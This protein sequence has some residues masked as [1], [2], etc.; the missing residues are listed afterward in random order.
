MFEEESELKSVNN[1]DEFDVN[2]SDSEKDIEDVEPEEVTP[3]DAEPEEVTTEEAAPEEA[4]PEEA[5][6]EEDAAESIDIIPDSIEEPKEN[7]SF[8]LENTNDSENNSIIPSLIFIV[9]YR[10]RE[11][12]YDFF[13]KHMLTILE[14]YPINYYKILYIH[15]KDNRSFN[16]G[17]M[18]NIGFIVVKQLYP[19]DYQNITLVFN[20]I[21]TMPYTK[22]M[23]TFPTKPGIIKHF[24]GFTYCLGGIVS[25]N[26][27]DFEM[28]NGFPNFWA[29]G[30]ED[31]LLNNRAKYSN[32]EID[33]SE[34]YNILDKNILHFTEGITR[35]VNRTE[36]DEYNNNTSEG[37]N[38]IFNL[39]YSINENGFVDVTQFFTSRE[40]NIS[41]SYIHDLRK[42]NIPF[43]NKKTY[44]RPM[45]KMSF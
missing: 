31:N 35:N 33:R 23:L 21:D 19:N 22:N 2:V 20:D 6:P 42:G 7:I 17:A 40:E 14:D 45:M 4:A 16:R 12:Q 8:I 11:Q 9:P 43:T 1:I 10:D 27:K 38:T 15:Q 26:A 5:A 44:R 34:F 18:K 39:E 3:A 37:I 24:Y 30:Y 32:L 13:S 29:W 41:Q 36:Y 28:I 25:I